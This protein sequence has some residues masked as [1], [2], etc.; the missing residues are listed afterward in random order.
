[1]KNNFKVWCPPS[2]TKSKFELSLFETCKTF[3]PKYKQLVAHRCAIYQLGLGCLEVGIAYRWVLLL[4]GVNQ[5]PLKPSQNTL[6]RPTYQ[7]FGAF[8]SGC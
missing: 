2:K 1:M 7:I 4:V 5:R 3:N 8:S 6:D